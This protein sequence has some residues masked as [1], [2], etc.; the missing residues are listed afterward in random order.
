M[1]GN[2]LCF[3]YL[4]EALRDRLVCGLI[5]GTVQKKLL[6]EADLTLVKATQIAQAIESAT[7][8]ARSLHQTESPLNQLRVVSGD[9]PSRFKQPCRHCGHSNHA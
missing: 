6:T 4:N 7:A 9:T 5:N 3:H 2:L 8:N 1:L